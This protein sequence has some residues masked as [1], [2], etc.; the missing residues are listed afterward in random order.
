MRE[1]M[2]PLVAHLPAALALL[3][4]QPN[5]QEKVPPPSAEDLQFYE[6]EVQPILATNCYKC[7]GDRDKKVRG[8]LWLRT[9][10]NVLRGGH[11]GP[12]IDPVEPDQSRI[13]RFINHE[14]REHR[15]PPKRKLAA[16]DIDVLTEWVQRG[17]PMPEI[18]GEWIYE[19]PDLVTEEARRFW[20]FQP[21]AK[22]APPAVQDGA[23]C[24]NEI[25][26][27]VLA[28][29]EAN[30]LAPV[31]EADRVSLI[32]RAT[33]DLTGLPPTPEEVRVLRRRPLRREPMKS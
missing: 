2:R 6:R 20:S 26:R 21:I 9:R 19:K 10:T 29:L 11:S 28:R 4:S 18:E 27:F 25:D 17:A 13:L 22:P 12:I 33:Y 23:W 5:A 24:R 1:L 31:A 15:M 32:R 7:H 8:E 30:G 3:V 16:G 14:D